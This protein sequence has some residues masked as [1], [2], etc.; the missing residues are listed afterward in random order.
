VGADRSPWKALLVRWSLENRTEARRGQG[1]EA[2]GAKR[3]HHWNSTPVFL[4]LHGGPGE[5]ILQNSS[6]MY[7]GPGVAAPL[8]IVLILIGIGIFLP[9]ISETTQAGQAVAPQDTTADFTAVDNQAASSEIIIPDTG[10]GGGIGGESL[11]YTVEQGDTLGELAITYN[12][13]VEAILSENPEITDPD[14][15]YTGQLIRIPGN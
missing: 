7:T 9:A 6:T 4:A 10:G 15:I 12:T 13:S 5:I 2:G 3:V 11:L 14:W 8:F 1:E